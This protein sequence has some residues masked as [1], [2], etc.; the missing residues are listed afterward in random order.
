MDN[1]IRWLSVAAR[2]IILKLPVT[3]YDNCSGKGLAGHYT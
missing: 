1:A 2:D 3:K